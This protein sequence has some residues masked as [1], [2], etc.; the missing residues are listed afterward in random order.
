VYSEQVGVN[1]HDGGRI[2]EINSWYPRMR[3]TR[4]AFTSFPSSAERL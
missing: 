2:G 4:T 1:L 3:K